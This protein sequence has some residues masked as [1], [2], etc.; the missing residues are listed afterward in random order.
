MSRKGIFWDNAVAKSFF[1]IIKVEWI[2]HQMFENQL[3]DQLWAKRQL[4]E[5]RK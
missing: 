4:K 2:Y 5:L 1:K 3:Q